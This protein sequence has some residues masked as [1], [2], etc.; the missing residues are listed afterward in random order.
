MINNKKVNNFLF[1]CLF[2]LRFYFGHQRSV[3]KVPLDRIFACKWVFTS[4][5]FCLLSLQMYFIIFGLNVSDF[6]FFM[7]RVEKR[8][9]LTKSFNVMLKTVVTLKSYFLK[10]KLQLFGQNFS[11][12]LLLQYSLLSTIINAVFEESK[13]IINS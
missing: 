4:F 12:P 6:L 2:N 9:N 10:S 1:Q 5:P 3:T 11:A 7:R 8:L 13:L